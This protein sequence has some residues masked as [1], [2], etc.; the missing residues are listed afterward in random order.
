MS[1]PAATARASHLRRRLRVLVGGD[2]V[3]AD[4]L[5]VL[6]GV[7][8]RDQGAAGG[9]EERGGDRGAVAAGAV[10]PHLAGRHLGDPAGQLVERDVD[11][12]LDRGA[13]RAR[14]RGG[15]R[16]RRRRGG[17]GPARGRR[18]CAVG[19]LPSSPVAQSLRVR[20]WPAR[21]DGRCRCGPARAGPRRRPR[22]SRRAG[23]PGCPTRSASR[24]RSRT[25]PSSPK[26]RVPGACPAAKAVRLRRSTTHSPA[27]MRRRS[28]SASASCTGREVG[29][30]RAGGVGRRHVHV[31]GRPG[32]R[33]RR[34]ARG[35]RSPRPGSAPGSIA[36]PGRWSRT[37]ASDWVAEQ[38]EPNPW[39]G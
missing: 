38:N 12:A 27:S 7:V 23:S 20:R 8:D 39:V 18:R 31:V 9:G 24:G 19:K 14:R 5:G 36:S 35:R 22:R 17:G 29:R 21:R 28:S 16:G 33:A 1:A 11:R 34:A 37:V 3:Q 26:L 15:R 30:G 4:L 13:L 32:A 2:Q 10:H 25:A 6:E